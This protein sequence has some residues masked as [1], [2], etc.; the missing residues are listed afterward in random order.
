MQLF[1]SAN[2]SEKNCLLD[3][4]ESRHC[5]KVLRHKEGQN[6]N[7]TNGKGAIFEAKILNPDP[8][9]IV[10]EIITK[11]EIPQK[12]HKI[13]IAIAPT[14]SI[15]RFE[16]FLEKTTEIGIDIITPILCH[17]TE[18]TKINMERMEKIL[19][20]AMKQSNRTYL[21]FIEHPTKF[22][23]IATKPSDTFEKF[24]AH[25][26]PENKNLKDLYPK[27]KN[28]LILIGPEG[29][30]TEDE[31]RIAKENNFASVNLSD[32]RLRTET[33]GVVACSIINQ[34]NEK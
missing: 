12:N 24:I 1:Y 3:E 17:R 34:I 11:K 30:F 8:K 29:D 5:V 20:A 23:E 16:W 6:I 13:H 21:P 27:N 14:K 2:F 32:A 19:V 26:T 4:I 18:R 31:I 33:A 28:V 25:Y 7:I 9:G 10:L 15:D 22:E